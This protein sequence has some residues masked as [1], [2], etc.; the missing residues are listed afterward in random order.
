MENIN[1]ICKAKT[2]GNNIV[3]KC[4][5]RIKENFEATEVNPNALIGSTKLPQVVDITLPPPTFSMNHKLCGDTKGF[6]KLGEWAWQNDP[7][8]N[9]RTK[10]PPQQG[11]GWMYIDD[12]PI[13]SIENAANM[14]GM[15]YYN[16]FRDGRTRFSIKD[17]NN[18]TTYTVIK[19]VFTYQEFSQY[20]TILI[21]DKNTPG[22]YFLIARVEFW[23][24]DNWSSFFSFSTPVDTRNMQWFNSTNFKPEQMFHSAG[25]FGNPQTVYE[26]FVKP[27]RRTTYNLTRQPQIISTFNKLP[28]TL[29]SQ[30]HMWFDGSD[31][32]GNGTILNDDEP[33]KNWMDKSNNKITMT[34]QPF[35]PFAPQERTNGDPSKTFAEFKDG[36]Y[37]KHANFINTKKRFPRSK[38]GILNGRSVVR[39][40]SYNGFAFNVPANTSYINGPNFPSNQK[41]IKSY[42]IF[43]VVNAAEYKNRDF[44]FGS[45]RFRFGLAQQTGCPQMW[46]RHASDNQSPLRTFANKSI[47]NKWAIISIIVVE[48]KGP[49][50]YMNGVLNNNYL[51]G[52]GNINAAEYGHIINGY[53]WGIGYSRFD[54][55]SYNWGEGGF[56]GDLAEIMLF[57]TP[58]SNKDRNQVEGYLAQ[59]WN[60]VNILPDSNP[61]IVDPN[62]SVQLF[63][64]P[65]YGAMGKD[66]K[67]T[68]WGA[69][70][71]CT[72]QNMPQ[73]QTIAFS[74]DGIKD[75][76]WVN[77]PFMRNTVRNFQVASDGDMWVV[78]DGAAIGYSSDG[79]NWSNTTI[80]ATN[81]RQDGLFVQNIT[82]GGPIAGW[83]AYCGG[84]NGFL[85][86]KDGKTWTSPN[87]KI[88][89]NGGTRHYFVDTF[90]YT[91]GSSV[92]FSKDCKTWE[93]VNVPNSHNALSGSCCYTGTQ[94]LVG[95]N[96]GDLLWSSKDLKEWTPVTSV[97]SF[98][99]VVHSNWGG[100]VY[101]L[102]SNEN[103]TL[104]GFARRSKGNNVIIIYSTDGGLTFTDSG[105][106]IGKFGCTAVNSITYNGTHFIA[107]I[108][109]HIDMRGP[110]DWK[111]ISS[112]DGITWE[113]IPSA[114]VTMGTSVGIQHNGL[115][116]TWSDQMC[117]KSNN[118]GVWG[119]KMIGRKSTFSPGLY[120]FDKLKDIGINS[121]SSF[122]VPKGLELVLYKS[123][124][125]TGPAKV[126]TS[127]VPDLSSFEGWNKT[128]G[129]IAIRPTINIDRNT[130]LSKL[131]LV[132]ANQNS[133]YGKVQTT[134]KRIDGNDM[135]L[136]DSNNSNNIYW[137]KTSD[138]ML[139]SSTSG[140]QKAKPLMIDGLIAWFDGKD[141]LG[142]GKV[143]PNGNITE[144]KD[145]SG[146]LNNTNGVIG[147]PT[148]DSAQG[149]VFDGKSYFNLPDGTL[150]F[151]DTSYTFY[152]VGN[153]SNFGGQFGLIGAGD[154]GQG[155]GSFLTIHPESGTFTVAWN[156][157]NAGGGG[158]PTIGKPFLFYTSYESGG[159]R[160]LGLNG[161]INVNQKPNS[162]RQSGTVM[163]IL[164]KGTNVG[165]MMGSIGE[166]L[167]Y[168]TNHS[169]TQKKFIEDY[170][171]EKWNIEAPLRDVPPPTNLFP[172]NNLTLWLDGADPL[173]NG[174]VPTNGTTMTVWNDKSGRNFNSTRVKGK[175]TYNAEQKAVYFDKDFQGCWFAFPNSVFPTEAYS[176]FFVLSTTRADV[177]QN[178][179]YGSTGVSIKHVPRRE[180][181]FHSWEFA[182]DVKP[183]ME[184]FKK[185][186]LTNNKPMLISALYD[187]TNRILKF[188]GVEAG[189]DQPGP[190]RKEITALNSIGGSFM[191]GTP[192][193]LGSIYEVIYKNNF[194]EV[195]NNKIEQ[196]LISKWKL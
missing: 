73:G 75:W 63:T 174:V 113:L 187:K 95:G 58:L 36:D 102:C 9:P 170:L 16:T 51:P 12:L 144:W 176:L 61:F 114:N 52:E 190:P 91:T 3:W 87:P 80:N 191:H 167:V 131:Q 54:L 149:V 1:W 76:Q 8:K 134:I 6:I 157:N 82:Y 104:C 138:F 183:P 55:D 98:A 125:M 116:S 132:E 148:Y 78:S 153:Y 13:S 4:H 17:I 60:L 186:N 2:V 142:T 33:L 27:Y 177:E 168:D 143:P 109:V 137:H 64:A 11:S 30:L 50:L 179:M 47:L 188:N 19:E 194:N 21:R 165:S 193:L 124:N 90:V 164:G 184:L 112:K 20:F 152:I 84:G 145:K 135:L 85:F 23:T 105:T 123:V 93:T 35:Q 160:I 26:L 120:G 163:N 88:D 53:D 74:P 24:D 92:W 182:P 121:L 67:I 44:I 141:P 118:V 147:T 130:D 166:V 100:G 40:N 62:T 150:P 49:N 169:D 139:A 29:L 59:K 115:G 94:Y 83:V 22:N 97:A 99:T 57:P 86:S 41:L 159:K 7:N 192:G 43:A 126:F 108:I 70:V 10:P 140:E 81:F 89:S 38:A 133:I 72:V 77:I 175:P 42:S 37:V 136:I 173:A 154:P 45:N 119:P 158:T 171:F 178:F 69:G 18:T 28:D 46:T 39:F 110:G 34:A 196:Y 189:R 15:E 103:I 106:N 195:E 32:M 161:I 68:T 71:L 117:S 5:P 79:L 129:S 56:A 156:N 48:N 101:V 111:Y 185:S 162:P 96:A 128:T 172:S 151:G 146:N 65:N 14:G 127:D 66:V 180:S 107:C 181:I 25:K 122:K 155:G 31:P